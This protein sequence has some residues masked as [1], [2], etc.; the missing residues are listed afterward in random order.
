MLRG[1]H[2]RPEGG[3]QVQGAGYR[4]TDCTPPTTRVLLVKIRAVH[5]KSRHFQGLLQPWDKIPYILLLCRSVFSLDYK[6]LKGKALKKK[7]E[8][9][10]FYRTFSLCHRTLGT[11][12]GAHLTDL[13]LTE[14]WERI[15]SKCQEKC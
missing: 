2:W 13:L 4:P 12:P 6:L 1:G 14:N 5:V 3:I 15:P 9:R 8:A 10:L 7:K 11:D